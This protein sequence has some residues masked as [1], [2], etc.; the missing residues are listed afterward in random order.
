MKTITMT[1]TMTLVVALMM[2]LLM[3]GCR[4]SKNMVP[5]MGREELAAAK[6]RYESVLGRN[7]EYEY[8][9]AKVK[10]SLDGKALSG[11]LNIEH[12]KHLSMTV[13]LLGIE[14]ARIEA[15]QEYVTVVD[16]VDKA[17][18]KVPIAEAAAKI[19]LEDEAK[20][21]AV[22]ALLLGRIFLPGKGLAAKGD[23]A[24]FVWYPMENNELQADYE[25]ERYQLSYV[26]SPD[27]Y[28]VATQVKVP[29]KESTFVWEYAS[30]TSVEK[31]SMP[32]SEI[33]SISG[34]RSLSAQLGISDPSVSKKTWKAFTPSS[35]YKQVSFAELIEI[36]KNIRK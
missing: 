8:L 4:S 22:E 24:K 20:L 18:A 35:N 34:A 28:L 30:P 9:Q 11:K 1:K 5:G 16:K 15:D 29:S 23:F 36:V 12:G 14:V 6:D 7:F 17:Y 31:G 2:T 3:T 27:N 13:T 21:E 25:A 32:T 33:L 19:G 26:M 10:Y